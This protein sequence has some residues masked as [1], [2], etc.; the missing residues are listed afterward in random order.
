MKK[1]IMLL[2][3]LTLAGTTY[4]K[5]TCPKD[6]TGIIPSPWPQPLCSNLGDYDK[7]ISSKIIDLKPAPNGNY[8]ALAYCTYQ[9]EYKD[10]RTGANYKVQCHLGPVAEFWSAEDILAFKLDPNWLP[11]GNDTTKPD[12]YLCLA[13][14]SPKGFCQKMPPAL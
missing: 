4:A 2:T 12:G 13:D 8:G 6:L 1:I 11:L 9:A 3:S 5:L 10:S 14:K 7:L